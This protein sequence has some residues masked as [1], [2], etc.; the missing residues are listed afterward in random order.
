MMAKELEVLWQKLLDQ[1]PDND[2]LRY[3]IRFVEPLRDK[4]R[5]LIHLDKSDILQKMRSLV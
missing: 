4:A 2:D 5:G 1:G 3:I